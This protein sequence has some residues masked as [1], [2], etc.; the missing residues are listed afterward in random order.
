MSKRL[1][2]GVFFLLVTLMLTVT[3]VSGQSDPTIVQTQSGAVQGALANGVIAFKGIPFAAPPVGDL[4]WR[5]PQPVQP[6]TGVKQTTAFV[7]DCMQ[8]VVDFEPIQTTPAED[9]LYLNVWM[10]TYAD[11]GDK[12]PVMVWIHGGGF[13]GGGTSEAIYDG[14]AFARQGIV[15]VSANYR[16]GRLGFF[17]HPALQAATNG[18]VG[19]FG[20]MDQI[21]ALKWVQNNVD[22]FGGDAQKVTII[23]ESAGGAS[24]LAL[25]TSPVTQGLFQQAMVMSGGGRLPLVGGQMTGGTAAAPSVDQVDAAFAKTLGIDGT[26]AAALA[27]LRALPADDFVKGYDLNAVLL[28]GL[29][30]QIAQIKDPATYD[31]SCRPPLS[32]TQMIDGKIVT[33]TPGDIIKNGQAQ[34]VP[35]IIGTTAA[36]LPEYFPPSITDPYSYFGAD[37]RAARS[38]YSLPFIA[39]AVLVLK[40]QSQLKDLLPVLSMGSD[41]TMHEPARFVAREYRAQGQPSWLYRFTY[42]AESTRPGSDKQAHA[43]ELPFMFDT[44]KA[45]YGAA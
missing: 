18:E 23:G 12:L 44:L 34:Y 15:V 16:L 29:S 28:V 40:G 6:W 24:V 7:H 4:R 31:P 2:F 9:C 26:D 39:S 32:G 20:Y 38:N 19:N 17:A 42:T 30:C 36:D 14:S 11:P 45:K 35:I 21:A 3:G 37:A 33:G 8:V 43:G 22:A 5:A 41:M 13:V 1:V 25:L 27:A 10:P